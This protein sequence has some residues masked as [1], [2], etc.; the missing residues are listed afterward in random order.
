MSL[1]V[2][3]KGL[4]KKIGDGGDE[5]EGGAAAKGKEATYKSNSA[6][7]QLAQKMKARDAA[8]AP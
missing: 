6:H 5:E 4:S 8:S 7:V 3:T 2:I 1:L